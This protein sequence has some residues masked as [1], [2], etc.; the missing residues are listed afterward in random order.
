MIDDMQVVCEAD[1]NTA[2]WHQL[3]KKYA[4][5]LPALPLF[6]RADPFIVPVW[7]AGVTPTGHQHPSTLWVENWTEKAAP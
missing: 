7:L 4:D 5:E 6:Y 2:L 3:Q 1:K